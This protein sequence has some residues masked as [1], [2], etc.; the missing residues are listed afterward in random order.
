MYTHN[1][2]TIYMPISIHIIKHL[3]ISLI[4]VYNALIYTKSD[5]YNESNCEYLKL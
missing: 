4:Y 3:P 5:I 1:M 2:T